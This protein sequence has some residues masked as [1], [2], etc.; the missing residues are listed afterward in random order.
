MKSLN[1]H[2]EE[3]LIINKKLK[4]YND[5]ETFINAINSNGLVFEKEKHG[6]EYNIYP[7]EDA[8]MIR[9]KQFNLPDPLIY[10]RM[11][12]DFFVALNSQ[13]NEGIDV[14]NCGFGCYTLLFSDLDTDG[15]DNQNTGKTKIL[16][17]E[18]NADVISEFL[19]NIA[20]SQK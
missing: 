4:R 20:K 8:G 1:Q 5:S 12:D 3:K 7:T 19:L 17:T 18:H 11:F 2:I 9:D 15:K 6:D 14:W 16:Y 13:D 10:I